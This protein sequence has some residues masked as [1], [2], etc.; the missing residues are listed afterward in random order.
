MIADQLENAKA[1]SLPLF[2]AFFCVLCCS[3][4]TKTD[5]H[6]DSEYLNVVLRA[7]PEL[8]LVFRTST[9]RVEGAPK[10]NDRTNIK[11]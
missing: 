3:N 9:R 4:I 7:I 8:W 5:C 11:Q 2:L 1:H 10:E 6:E